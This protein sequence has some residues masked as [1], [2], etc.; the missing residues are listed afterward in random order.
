MPFL[1][2][3]VILGWWLCGVVAWLI[4]ERRGFGSWAPWILSGVVFGP[5]VVLFALLVTPPEYAVDEDGWRPAR[6]R[7]PTCRRPNAADAT[8][9]ANCGSALD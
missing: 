6:P 7:C 1:F 4:A 8:I 5:F 3:P 9:C 2:L